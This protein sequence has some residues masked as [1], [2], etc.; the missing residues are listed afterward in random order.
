MRKQKIFDPE[1]P[2]NGFMLRAG[3]P[4]SGQVYEY[5][6][7]EILRGRIEPDT[8]LSEANL[9]HFFEVSRQPVR[10]ALLRL[11]VDALVNIYPQRGSVVTKISVPLVR[12]AQLV[13][14][15]V[16]VE[17]VR[18]AMERKDPKLLVALETELAVQRTFAKANQW[19]RFFQSDQAFHRHIFESSGTYGVWESLEGTRAQLDRVRHADLQGS[20]VLQLLVDQHTKVFECIADS[21]FDGATDAMRVHLRRV[22]E[23][24]DRAYKHST[25]H[26]EGMETPNG[27]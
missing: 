10:E 14:E 9:C 22:L 27:V 17:M 13:R 11:S 19:E 4:A 5:L 7:G 15:A 23:S 1:A 26:F 8:H 3:R 21:D 6:R 18:R 25:D 16:E 2:Q 12:Q 20:I 24:L